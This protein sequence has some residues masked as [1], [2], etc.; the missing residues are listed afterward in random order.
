MT[1]KVFQ[2]LS[3]LA[4]I[5]AVGHRG[6]LSGCSLAVNGGGFSQSAHFITVSS[7]PVSPCFILKFHFTRTS[8]C[9]RGREEDILGDSSNSRKEMCPRGFQGDS[10]MPI[11][12]CRCCLGVH[13]QPSPF[14]I[15]HRLPFH[16]PYNCSLMRAKSNISIVKKRQG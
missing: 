14:E 3:L 6:Q 4:L 9:H 15:S 2:Q 11:M 7:V 1:Q 16:T 5:T 8:K 10:Q 13:E 12:V